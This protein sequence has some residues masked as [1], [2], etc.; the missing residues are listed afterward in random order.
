MLERR[1]AG[2]QIGLPMLTVEVWQWVMGRL[3][4]PL[5]LVSRLIG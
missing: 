2:L 3:W 1:T 4:L 5:V